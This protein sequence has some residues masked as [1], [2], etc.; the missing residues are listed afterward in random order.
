MCL[1]RSEAMTLGMD[2]WRLLSC[3]RS[4]QV[5][6]PDEQGLTQ[7][8]ARYLL[9]TNSVCVCGGGMG[10]GSLARLAPSLPRQAGFFY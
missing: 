5:D 1:N 2:V 4:E 10:P 9:M 3:E 6:N 8:L 7:T